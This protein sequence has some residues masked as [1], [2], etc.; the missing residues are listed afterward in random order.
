M[1][2]YCKDIIEIDL[3][4]FDTSLVTDMK[5]MFSM[6]SSLSSLNVSGLNTKRVEKF[7]DMFFKCTSLT[8]LNLESF[9]N[10]SATS[11]Y[12]MFYGCI[13]LEYINIK[14]FDE[15]EN[16][17]VN[18]MF[19]NIPK[20]AVICSLS[21]PP[22]T[23]FTI[24]YIYATAVNISWQGYGLNKFVISYGLQNLSTPEEGHEI[25]VTGTN[26]IIKNLNLSQ[27]Y[28]IYIKTD[29]VSKSS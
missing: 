4:K 25:D 2:Y 27:K 10:P 22:P 12:R 5:G 9:T 1:F 21:C 6:Y 28:D 13:N 11:L 16:M 29:C 26:Y 18:E 19:Y 14:N 15:K 20:D 23:N 8:S 7:E 3:T 17:N 24:I